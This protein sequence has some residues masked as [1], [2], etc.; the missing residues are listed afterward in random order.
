MLQIVLFVIQMII[1]LKL[2][3]KVDLIHV[4]V[5]L[6][7]ISLKLMVNLIHVNPVI[8][9]VLLVLVLKRLLVQNVPKTERNQQ[10]LQETLIY[11]HVKKIGQKLMMYVLNVTS[12]VMVVLLQEL[13][14]VQNV[15][16][17]EKKKMNYVNQLMEHMKITNQYQKNVI[18]IV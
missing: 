18:L 4:Y 7:S 6:N 17:R 12:H 10:V 16:Q 14:T 11:V 3:K 1:S 9:H 5:N 13:K 15:N 2:L 8:I